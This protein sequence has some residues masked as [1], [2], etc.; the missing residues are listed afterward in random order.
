MKNIKIS[1]LFIA[2]ISMASF[3]SCKKKGCT[4]PAACN[5]NEKA[6]ND[7]GSC[8][9][10]CIFQEHKSM[11]LVTKMTATWCGPCGSWGWITNEELIDQLGG[12]AVVMS[13]Y[14]P[15]GLN[16][17]TASEWIADFNTLGTPN[18]AVNGRNR[19]VYSSTG[20]IFTST[21]KSNCVNA[22]DSTYS[23]SPE[24]QAIYGAFTTEGSTITV[25][26]LTQFY[27][28]PSGEYYLGAYIVENGVI[29]DQAG[30]AGTNASHPYVL[31]GSMDGNP[32]GTL[33]VNGST[34]TETMENTFSMT[35]E[36]GWVPENINVALVIW[37][38]VGGSYTFINAFTK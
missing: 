11:A 34:G 1:I 4:D 19:T 31:R 21:T 7:D 10:E 16:N 20:G 27:G 29:A 38:K 6:K 26:T 2:I 3:S 35:M 37:K 32:Y 23:A 28:S 14:Y 18:W 15:Q 22:S 33:L 24:A 25:N 36:S 17:P 9:Y 13:L 30:D 5:Y 12:K 8:D